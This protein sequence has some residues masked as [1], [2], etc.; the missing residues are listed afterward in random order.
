MND[1]LQKKEEAVMNLEVE[2]ENMKNSKENSKKI[3]KEIKD[4]ANA[5]IQKLYH[6]LLVSQTDCRNPNK[7]QVSYWPPRRKK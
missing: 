4:D 6:E 2:L 5:R 1:E 7:R 3:E